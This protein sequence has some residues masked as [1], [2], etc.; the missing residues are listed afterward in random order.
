MI[1]KLDWDSE[2][3]EARVGAIDYK[4]EMFEFESLA[5]SFDLIYFFTKSPFKFPIAFTEYFSVSITDEKLTYHKKIL[6]A[7][8]PD[9]SIRM[10]E[11]EFIPSEQ[12]ISIAI[13]SGVYS[14][15][16]VDK[17]FPKE[18]FRELYRLWCVN[19]I[20]RK[21]AEEVFV[22][23]FG[24]VIAGLIT[25]GIK[26]GIPD[27]GLLA[28]DEVYR[29]KGIGHKLV[30]AVEYWAINQK[31][32]N[33]LQVVTQSANLPACIFYEKAG[34]HLQQKQYVYHCWKK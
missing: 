7:N 19:S 32:V 4:D 33:E 20:N 18:K 24:G 10:L 1:R 26:S 23:E 3:L 2:F 12:V 25:V 22:Y 16:N 15:F 6:E 5:N 17:L 31:K 21:I 8:A 34:F 11:K 28:V 13:Q 9:E 14:R 30:A 29:G 27:I